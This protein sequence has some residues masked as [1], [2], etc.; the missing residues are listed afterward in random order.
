MQTPP[1][2]HRIDPWRLAAENARLDG[3]LPLAALPRLAALLSSTEG[4]VRVALVA[5]VDGQ[6]KRYIHGEVSAVVELVCQRCLGRLHMPL[7]ARVS[8]GLVRSE[9]EAERLPEDREPL[10][11]TGDEIAVATLVEDELLLALPQIPRHEDL[12][13]CAAHGYTLPGDEPPASR[14]PQ[15]FAALASL[16]RDPNKE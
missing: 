8:L 11:L 13:E 7:L 6:G 3:A 15:P 2:P 9:A 12:R 10:L 16:L 5:T 4:M 1:L 14:P